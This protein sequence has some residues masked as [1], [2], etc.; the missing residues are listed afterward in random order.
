MLKEAPVPEVPQTVG[1]ATLWG[2]CGLLCKQPPPLAWKYTKSRIRL[3]L[4]IPPAWQSP[5]Q[6]QNESTPP[7]CSTLWVPPGR[8]PQ[9]AAFPAFPHTNGAL[10]ARRTLGREQLCHDSEK[11]HSERTRKSGMAW[12]LKNLPGVAPPEAPRTPVKPA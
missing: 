11:R 4:G 8:T 6:Y 12:A 3:L 9:R 10:T 2:L 5:A 7:P 1:R